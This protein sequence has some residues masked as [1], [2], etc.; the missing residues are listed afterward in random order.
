MNQQDVLRRAREIATAD[1]CR[2]VAPAHVIIAAIEAG[3][4]T[5]G[6]PLT[7]ALATMRGT[8]SRPAD[9][10]QASIEA[11]IGAGRL[12]CSGGRFVAVES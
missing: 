3:A 7:K 9:H 6:R 11:M 2:A 4:G 1:M 8:W 5:P 12:Y 10:W